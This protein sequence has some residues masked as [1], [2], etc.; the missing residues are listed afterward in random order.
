[1]NDIE[2]M[3]LAAE[4][5]QRLQ[6]APQDEA[7]LKE[8]SNWCQSDAENLAAF[9]RVHTV[10]DS[11]DNPIVRKNAQETRPIRPFRT[12]GSRRL[13]RLFAIA[14]TVLVAV[15]AVWWQF[16]AHRQEQIRTLTT[17]VVEHD[18]Q[19]LSDGSKVDL[20]GSTRIVTNYTRLERKVIMENGEAFFRVKKDRGRPFV[21][22]A[23]SLRVTAVGTAFSVQRS[24]DRTIVT[25]SEGVVRIE[26]FDDK[27]FD[28]N[29]AGPRISEVN[30][31]DDSGHP[32]QAGA[33]D[34]VTFVTA[35]NRLMLSRVDPREAWPFQEGVLR[36]VDEPLKNVLAEVNRHRAHPI[37]LNDAQLA[38]ALYT[39]TVYEDR[40]DDWL[41]ALKQV[42]P[43]RTVEDSNGGVMLV[44]K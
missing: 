13:P 42:F 29:G 26:P 16:L 2:R 32:V 8:W 24:L 33:G 31:T 38:N 5:L 3:E 39:G 15:G 27:P 9:D 11:F 30:K 41:G 10:W 17:D 23:G 19:F 37:I 21:V 25:V 6:S 43:I 34:R 44:K 18:N 12:P 28:R 7:I 35:S 20:A 1:M 40:I 36:F 22:Q 4:W 14:A